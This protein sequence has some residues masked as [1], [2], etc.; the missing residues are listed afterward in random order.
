MDV[1]VALRAR[2]STRAFLPTPVSKEM[3]QGVLDNA[4][5]SPSGGNLQPWKVVA[6]TGD[7]RRAVIDAVNAAAAVDAGSQEGDNPMYPAELWE[8][9]RTRR[10][11]VGEQM[12]AQLGIPRDDKTA[13]LARIMENFNFFDAPVG[14]FF[15]TDDRM[16]AGQ[17]AH[18]GMFMQSL[19]LAAVE[20]G[21]A[22]CMQE[23]WA[24]RRATLKE[25]FKLDE[26]DYVY[27]GMSLGYADP[28][29]P[30]NQLRSERAAVDEFTI[31][32]GWS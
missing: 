27:C 24:M 6:V 20:H 30:V 18:L 15:V 26:H 11:Q 3:L 23:A 28:E 5:W 29:H 8:P 12:Y 31:W 17:W 16:G 14:L 1:N 13:R 2:I 7:A 10:Y 4:R 9:L 25:H 22:T 32:H 21:L 19:A